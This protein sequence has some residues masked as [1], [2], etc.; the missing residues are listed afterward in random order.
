[1]K[2][3]YR[4]SGRTVEEVLRSSRESFF[5]KNGHYATEE[6]AVVLTEEARK[7]I[8]RE[9]E[10]K[11][12]DFA[13]SIKV[14]APAFAKIKHISRNNGEALDVSDWRCEYIGMVGTLKLCMIADGEYKGY[15]TAEFEGMYR[16]ETSIGIPETVPNGI[17]LT[18]K[19]SVYEFELVETPI[20]ENNDK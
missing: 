4:P 1:M 7:E 15:C 5:R 13:D 2:K 11:M 10:E 14:S 18:T 19:N 20:K 16:L 3:K 17:K 6:E 12:S 8:R 9:R